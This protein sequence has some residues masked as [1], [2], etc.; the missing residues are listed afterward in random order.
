[1]EYDMDGFNYVQTLLGKGQ[2]GFTAADGYE[3]DFFYYRAMGLAVSDL[4]GDGKLDAAFVGSSEWGSNGYAVLGNGD[5]TFGPAYFG[6]QQFLTGLD[7]RAVAVGDFTNDGIPDLV[8]AGQTVNVLRGHGDG[9][10][11]DPISHT[12]NGS[13]HTGVVT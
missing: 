7:S 6:G 5:G 8:V 3:L 9:W 1:G 13:M 10:F 11:D 4:N 12:A 2:G